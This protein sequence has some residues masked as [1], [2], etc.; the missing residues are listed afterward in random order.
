MTTSR[1]IFGRLYPRMNR[2]MEKA[3]I[4]IHRERMLAGLTGRVIE[5]GAG[6]GASFPF[7]P[8]DVTHLSAVEPESHLR[9]RAKS[10]AEGAKIPTEVV[11][12]AADRLPFPDA[13][14]DAAVV[15]LVLCSVPEQTEALNEI[16]RVLRPGGQLR[17]FEH[18]RA[19]SPGLR[20]A[21]RMLD[22]TVGP[23]LCGG[24]HSGRDTL[25]AITRA[26]FRIEQ[27]ER[28]RFP[29]TSVP[30]PASQHVLGTAV[31]SA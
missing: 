1:P 24:C 20:R 2:A 9:K 17:F 29:E 30:M 31:A 25:S 4:S 22:A 21:Q 7:Y 27:C 14:F 19:E 13:H 28:F 16:M 10:A 8:A 3:G 23:A 11:D 5:I 12:A 26:G 15:S 6:D 18:V